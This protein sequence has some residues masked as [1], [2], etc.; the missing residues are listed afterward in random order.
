[1]STI[2]HHTHRHKSHIIDRALE[3]LCML[4]LAYMLGLLSGCGVMSGAVRG[5]LAGLRHDMQAAQQSWS[6]EAPRAP[7]YSHFSDGTQASQEWYQMDRACRR[8]GREMPLTGDQ[9]QW[10]ALGREGVTND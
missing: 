1:M 10:P 4:A 7:Y 8:Q 6:Q 2:S 9:S 3:A 5:G